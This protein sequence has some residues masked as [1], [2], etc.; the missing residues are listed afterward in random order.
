[1]NSTISTSIIL[2]LIIYL[3]ISFAQEANSKQDNSNKQKDKILEKS[4]KIIVGDIIIR[5]SSIIKEGDPVI[6]YYELPKGNFQVKKVPKLSVTILSLSGEVD[7]RVI[8][9]SPFSEPG[10]FMYHLGNFSSGDKVSVNIRDNDGNIYLSDYRFKVQKNRTSIRGGI[11]YV[12]KIGVRSSVSLLTRL[13]TWNDKITLGLNVGGSVEDTN[14][15]PRS[16][17]IAFSWEVYETV[18]LY[19][20]LATYENKINGDIADDKLNHTLTTGMTFDLGFSKKFFGLLG[21]GI[22]F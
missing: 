16:F 4:V 6:F 22:G 10:A 1:M 12:G 11:S 8:S 19:I 15:K 18:D 13:W 14:E 20:G 21:S 7:D 17:H 3:N 5:S 2:F 9:A